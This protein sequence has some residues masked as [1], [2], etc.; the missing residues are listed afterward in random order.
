[1]VP[2]VIKS[3]WDFQLNI[4]PEFQ[5]WILCFA[6]VTAV[7]FF[8][9][10]CY[11]AGLSF[12]PARR[13]AAWLS[14]RLPTFYFFISIFNFVFLVLVVQWLPDWTM[15]EYIAKV[16][17]GLGGTLKHL[18]DCAYSIAIIA[19]FCIAVAFKDRIAQLLGFD[20][21]TLF[22]FKVRDC[23]TCMGSSRFKPIE[24]AVWKVEDLK[25]ADP[26]LANNVFVE[27]FLGYNER[28]TTRVHNNAGSSC[29][30]KEQLQLNFDEDDEEEILYIFVRNQK[31]MGTSDLARG[32]VPAGK[33]KSMVHKGA[34]SYGEMMRWTDEFFSEP[35]QLI[36]RGTLWLRAA[37]IVDEDF[38]HSLM[39]ELTAC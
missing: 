13:F 38:N 26:F 10:P 39:H 27:F 8:C 23:L 2:P 21:K 32:E 11:C 12:A 6:T 1:M 9:L 29:A 24:L 35:I 15:M 30:L 17:K 33:L 18:I 37:P 20:H 19:A 22:R 31:V 34:R 36:P 25:S 5:G 14:Q 3:I 28:I 4:H 7:F 16:G